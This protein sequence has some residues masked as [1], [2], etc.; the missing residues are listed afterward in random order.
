MLRVTLRNMGYWEKVF[1]W[2]RMAPLLKF[3]IVF[4]F[5]LK[6]RERTKKGTRKPGF[7]TQVNP[8]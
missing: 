8:R 3:F 1:P 6:N 2:Q 7:E 4:V 5:R